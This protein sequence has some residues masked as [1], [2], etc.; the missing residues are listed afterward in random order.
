LF[1]VLLLPVAVVLLW[2]R[3]AQAYSWMIKHSYG[4]CTVCHTDPSG[5]EMLTQ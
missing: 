5:G 3:P 2:S 4:G 1:L